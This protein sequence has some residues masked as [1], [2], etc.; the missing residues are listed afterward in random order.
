MIFSYGKMLTALMLLFS[1]LCL[2][3]RVAHAT[4]DRLLAPMA[5]LVPSLATDDDA[6][7]VSLSSREEVIGKCF[8]KKPGC[9]GFAGPI[10]RFIQFDN[11]TSVIFSAGTLICPTCYTHAKYCKRLPLNA[12]SGYKD[13]RKVNGCIRGE[14][15][16]ALE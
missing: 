9:K 14:C 4:D 3:I 1:L 15:E 7:T 5:D 8:W 10:Y 13:G 6:V 12:C 11:C 2:T 16:W